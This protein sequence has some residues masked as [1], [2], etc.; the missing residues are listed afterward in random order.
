MQVHDRNAVGGRRTRTASWQSCGAGSRA[1]RGR[2]PDAGMR[3]VEE[4]EGA[5]A[6]EVLSSRRVRNVRMPQR[7][8]SP[9][10][11]EQHARGPAR[12]RVGTA[13]PRVGRH[14]GRVAPSTG[15]A[16][17]AAIPRPHPS[18]I[19]R[20]RRGSTSHCC[21]K[22][23]GMIVFCQRITFPQLFAKKDSKMRC[24][25]L[26]IA[27][28]AWL[29]SRTGIPSRRSGVSEHGPDGTQR[30]RRHAEPNPRARW[31]AAF[32][33]RVAGPVPSWPSDRSAG[34]AAAASSPLLYFSAA[35]RAALPSSGRG[36]IR[37]QSRLDRLRPDRPVRHGL[38]QAV[39]IMGAAVLDTSAPEVSAGPRSC[40]A[41]RRRASHRETPPRRRRTSTATSPIPADAAMVDY[42]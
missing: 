38:V 13:P 27:E 2:P 35:Q 26:V 40:R 29:R 30:E 39:Q 23:A 34:R 16:V 36:G 28:G 31:S 33:R 32:P 8:G 19:L 3:Q 14:P 20:H 6:R 37:A 24:A 10:A 11:D 9:F 21:L 1:R 17:L 41:C 7:S 18:R 42:D 4:G 5:G 15:G 12:R 22:I 25:R